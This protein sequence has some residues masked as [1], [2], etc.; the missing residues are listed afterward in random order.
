MGAGGSARKLFVLADDWGETT[1]WEDIFLLE[2]RRQLSS[3][4]GSWAQKLGLYESS[5]DGACSPDEAD[6]LTYRF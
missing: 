1:S 3:K 4:P 5:D 6:E 2:P